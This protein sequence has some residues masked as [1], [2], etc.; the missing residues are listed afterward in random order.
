[1]A[2]AP[3]APDDGEGGGAVAGMSLGSVPPERLFGYLA[4]CAGRSR[5]ARIPRRPCSRHLQARWSNVGRAGGRSGGWSSSTC[6]RGRSSTRWRRPRCR[7]VTPSTPTEAAATRAR[8]VSP[9]PPTSGWTSTSTPGSSARSSSRSTPWS[10]CGPSWRPGAGPATPSPWAPTPTRTSAVKA[11]TVSPRGSSKCW[12]RP[13]R[14]T[15][16]STPPRTFVGR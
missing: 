3:D 10:A 9:A 4:G 6:G 16:A 15:Q 11:S 7:S 12:P 8:T 5:T 1:M 13:G 2:I 14:S